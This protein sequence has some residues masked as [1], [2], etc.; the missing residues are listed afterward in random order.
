MPK[1]IIKSV[2][3]LKSLIGKHLGFSDYSTITQE[4]VN[5]FADAT[6][7]HQWIH[8]DVERAK[9]GPFGGPIAHG[10]LT[11]SLGPVFLPQI[12]GV[13]GVAMGVNYGTNKVRF[14]S[15]VP[16]G[17][18]LRAG[19]KL[20]NVEDVTGGVQITLET[21]FEVEGAKK[22]SCVAEVVFRYYL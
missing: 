17:S 4:Q 21:T 18:K 7:Y 5:I 15:P 16:V 2:D 1:L 19:V 20:L 11:L 10:Y 14:P 22:P 8:I 6:G 13:E 3:E 12:F 9:A